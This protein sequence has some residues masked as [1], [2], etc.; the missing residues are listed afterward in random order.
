MNVDMFTNRMRQLIESVLILSLLAMVLLTFADVIGRRF[1][2]IPI[3]GAHY[4]TEH[5]MAVI[6]FSGLP[7]LTS[8]RG[9][10]AVDLFDRF[11]MTD[12][13][14][15]WRYLT[16][17]LICVILLLISYQFFIAA[18]DAI[19]IQE[20]SQALLIPRSYMYALISFSC[21]VSACASVLPKQV[22]QD[23]HPE[24]SL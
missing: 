9:H 5:L 16:N 10:L 18:M 8:A 4:L 17:G 22:S 2:N 6:V 13:M 19:E 20:V 3:Y 1:F 21:F 7:L 11:I 14:R 23:V 12:A 24:E 15:W